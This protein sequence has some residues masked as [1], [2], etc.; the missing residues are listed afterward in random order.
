MNLSDL[1]LKRPITT[2]MIF[3]A[4]IVIGVFSLRKLSIDLLPDVEFPSLTVS[5][6]YEG[7]SPKEIETLITEPIERAASTAQNIENVTST[8]SEGSS[9]VSIAFVWGT[10]MKDAANDMRERVA[11]VRGMLPENATDPMIYKFDSSSMPIVNLGL[12]GDMPLDK[13]R[14]YADDEIK[15]RLEQIAGVAAVSVRGGLEREIHVDVDRSQMEALGLSFSQITNALYNENL[16]MP[17]GYLETTR[18]ELLLRTSGQYTSLQQ[19]ANT[20]IGYQNGTA[21][22]LHQ[23]AEVK[24]SFKEV[25]SDTR[26]GGKPGVSLSVQ[27][28]AGENT[29]KVS[30]RVLKQIDAINKTLPSGMKLFVTRDTAKFIR[31]SINQM[32]SS[33]LMGAFLAV[34]ILIVFLRNIRSTIIIALAIPIAIVATFI[35][36][37]AAKLSL[38]MMSLGG[39]VLGIGM[40]L[41]NSVVVLENIFRHREWGEG[42]EES[43]SVGTKEVSAAITASTLTTLCVFFPMFFAAEGMQG[44]FF[45]QLAYTI[46]FSL[47]ASL[48]VALTLVPVMSARYLHIKQIDDTGSKSKVK[49]FL[50]TTFDNLNDKYG[51]S[52]NWILD[53]RLWVMIICPL[54]L[55]VVLALA[56]KIGVELMP[57]VDE[58][59]IS[60]SIQLPVGT[61][62]QITDALTKKLE[63][64]VQEN[65]PEMKNMRT[66]VGGGG[67]FFGH[68]STSHTADIGVDLVEK[69][70]R[71]RST[72]DVI[73]DL[74]KKTAGFPDAKIWI[75]ARGSMMTRLLG[76]RE[77]RVAVD[78]RG[79]DLDLGATLAER[80][81]TLVEGVEGTVN[82]RVS[83]EE[84]KPELTVL[85]DRDKA[86]SL[87][88]NLTTI[89]NTVN[90]G[91]TGTVAT[92]YR[93]GGDEYDV[94]VRMKEADRLS[95]DNVETFALRTGSANIS[96]SNI[97]NI[98]ESKGPIAIQRRDQE[99][100]VTVS[101]S[102][103]GRDFGSITRDINAKL[104]S[105]SVPE[106]FTV[107]LSGEQE[108]QSKSYNSLILTFVL[109]L[110]LVY[111]VMAAQYESL[112]H[113]FVIMF[114][115]PFSAIGVIL[116]LFLTGTNMSVPVFIGIIM[117]AGI[118]VN[119]AIVLVD[120]INLMRRQGA[121]LRE[122]IVE[123]GRRRLRPI[124][125]TTLTTVFGMIPLAIGLGEGSE[126]QAPMARTVLGGLTV[127]TVFTLFYIPTLYSLMEGAREKIMNRKKI[128]VNS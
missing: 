63:V 124:L 11:R 103:A 5:T 98:Q 78:I 4:I 21:V 32:Q 66:N 121:E 39:L 7:A 33:A 116:M 50:K 93:E 79:Y 70:L 41:D 74:R 65:V 64:I 96:L 104:A 34:I 10:D 55:A 43:A 125:M 118:V 44:V 37:Y 6:T 100:L 108:E 48:L 53:H 85:V 126:M 68:S 12:T 19:I 40:L 123:S 16:D 72:D 110:M 69:K 20:V 84:G 97:S 113:P 23:V 15:Y 29:V 71:K 94:R 28:Q 106:G 67:G 119:N 111:M 31:D 77:E 92:R 87:G 1:A 117:L 25:R 57:Q 102:I 61:K 89:A 73:N 86:S 95:L 8:S 14:K 47:I 22:F 35:L 88:L 38:N 60:V 107:R 3:I 49:K 120:Y 112:L 115:I 90:T 9:S 52:L 62:F 82:V 26:L 17:G 101:S 91:L 36:M 58:G 27:R 2:Y 128:P 127:A 109:A 13:I 54:M 42:P 99:R 83:R 18:N 114:S 122:A 46:S 51:N 80:V 30:D 105:F 76:G 59:N 75:S 45:S 56:P 81:K 24:D